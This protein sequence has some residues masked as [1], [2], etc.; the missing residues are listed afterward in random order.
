MYNNTNYE[1]NYFFNDVIS[2]GEIVECINNLKNNK[3]CGPD[4]IPNEIPYLNRT[5]LIFHT[6]FIQ[7]FYI[8]F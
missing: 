5:N 3:A 7:I 2:F 4:Q 6:N 1:S 8:V